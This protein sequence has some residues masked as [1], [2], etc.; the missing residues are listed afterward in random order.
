MS[1]VHYFQRYSQRENVT[2]NNTLLL[3]SRLYNESSL[4]FGQL[5]NGLL[6][7]LDLDVGVRFAQQERG[8]NSIPDGSIHQGSFQ[9]LIETKLHGG[10]FSVGQLKNHCK[11]FSDDSGVKVLLALGPTSIASEKEKKIQEF[12]Q[13]ENKLRSNYIHFASITFKNLVSGFREVISEYDFQLNSIIEDYE[14]FCL[15]EGL[16]RRYEDVLLA[17]PCGATLKINLK[18]GVYYAPAS[19]NYS[20]FSHIGVYKNKAIRGVG[21]LKNS[22]IANLEPDGNLRVLKSSSEVLQSQTDQIK[23]IIEDAISVG[24]RIKTGYRFFCVGEFKRCNFRKSSS[25]GMRGKKYFNLNSIF[26]KDR[27]DSMENL[28]ELLNGKTWK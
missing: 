22:I 25:R 15:N 4:K 9:I 1:A 12:L 13:T 8:D 16:I 3:L 18:N 14:D 20:Y 21:K 10:N 11:S 6:D 2:T 5:L 24:H 17:V 26:Q 23:S 27:F 7:D 19:R 28:T